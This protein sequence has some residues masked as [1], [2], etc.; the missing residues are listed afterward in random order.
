MKRLRILVFVSVL[1]L[2]GAIVALIGLPALADQGETGAAEPS[3]TAHVV[4]FQHG[5]NGYTGT[6]DTNLVS[7]FP[8]RVFSGTNK[9]TMEIRTDD[10]LAGLLRFDLRSIPK[11]AKVTKATLS[12]Y[13]PYRYGPREITVGVYKVL[14]RWF[15]CCATWNKATDRATWAVPGAN[16]IGT[17]REGVPVDEV[18]MFDIWRWYDFDVTPLVKEWVRRP[19]TNEGMAFKAFGNAAGIKIVTMEHGGIWMHPKLMVEYTTR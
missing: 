7:W 16:G 6:R 12:V 1:L 11:R 10:Q 8:K 4:T 9:D 17:D 3:A 2:I 15:A 14:R 19:V 18:T 5:V 13:V